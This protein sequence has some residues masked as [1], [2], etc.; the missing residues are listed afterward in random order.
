M[1]MLAPVM[2]RYHDGEGVV[3]PAT[4]IAATVVATKVRRAHLEWL[5]V[6]ATAAIVVRSTSPLDSMMRAET[7]SARLLG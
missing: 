7:S 4:Q 6:R 5:T 1:D 2:T 3:S